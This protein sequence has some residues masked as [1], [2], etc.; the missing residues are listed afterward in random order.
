[1]IETKIQK[2]KIF[3]QSLYEDGS[4]RKMD[5][6]YKIEDKMTSILSTVT[7]LG[8]ISI[9]SSSPILVMRTGNETKAQLRSLQHVPPPTFNDITITLQCKFASTCNSGC[10]FSLKGDI[11]LIDQ[12]HSRLLVSKDDGTIKSEIYLSTPNPVD[13]TCIDDLTVAVSFPYSKQIQIIN[14]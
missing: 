7:S 3:M 12:V 14:I 6:K 2:Y 4:I 5:I 10:S 8:T 1:M 9:E 13:G 11:V